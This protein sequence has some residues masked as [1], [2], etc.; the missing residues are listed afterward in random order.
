MNNEP[1]GPHGYSIPKDILW[2]QTFQTGQF[3]IAGPWD[4]QQRWFMPWGEIIPE[5]HYLYWQVNIPEIDEPFLQHQ[6]EI[7]W[8]IIDMPF[9][10]EFLVGWKNTKDYFMDHAC[11]RPPG[12]DWMMIDGID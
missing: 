10:V 5:Y 9:D 3:I 12:G 2:E 1:N 8:L 6:G 4:G 11:W 7:Y